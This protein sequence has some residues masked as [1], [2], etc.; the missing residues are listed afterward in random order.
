MYMMIDDAYLYGCRCASSCRTSGGNACRSTDMGRA[1]C[2]YESACEWRGSRN[3]W[4]T[5]RTAYTRNSSAAHAQRDA[6]Q[7]WWNVQTICHRRHRKRGVPRYGTVGHGLPVRVECWRVYRILHIQSFLLRCCSW[8]LA[9]CFRSSWAIRALPVA[10]PWWSIGTGTST[11]T[12]KTSVGCVGGTESPWSWRRKNWGV[13]SYWTLLPA[14]QFGLNVQRKILQSK[15]I[16]TISEMVI[17]C[18][19]LVGCFWELMSI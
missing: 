6:G 18:C 1:G 2:R 15:C 19:W 14:A 11:G 3:A 16:I 13:S 12:H 7:G 10:G 8:F 4:N 9:N 5:S 17:Y